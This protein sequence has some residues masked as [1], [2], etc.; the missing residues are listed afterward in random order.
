MIPLALKVTLVLFSA[1]VFRGAHK[2]PNSI[3]HG[4]RPPKNA[5]PAEKRDW[6]FNHYGP[7]LSSFQ[8]KVCYIITIFESIFLLR[9]QYPVFNQL[10]P[11]KFDGKT[12]SYSSSDAR[13]FALAFG[14]ASD[15][16]RISCQ[17]RLGSSFTWH[18]AGLRHGTEDDSDET[19]G[20]R[21]EEKQTKQKLITTGPYSIVRHPSYTAFWM[22]LIGIT[23]YH[24]L[25]GSFVRESGIVSETTVGKVVLG[26][27]IIS[28]IWISTFLA[29]RIDTED[30]TLRTTFGKEWEM[31][32]KQV[33]WRTIPGVW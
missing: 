7:P 5:T 4:P 26:V 2:P 13:F 17:R 32:R 18:I 1:I 16:L 21:A 29:L 11:V 27:W 23:T 22:S 33:P 20:P 19:A 12:S 28:C 31:W 14:I 30:E 24:L 9:T 10:L 8:R 3:L 15:L 6:I 25:P